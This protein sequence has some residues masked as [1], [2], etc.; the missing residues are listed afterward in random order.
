MEQQA[1][2]SAGKSIAGATRVLDVPSF[3][4]SDY[5]LMS[6]GNLKRYDRAVDWLQERSRNAD[7]RVAQSFGANELPGSSVAHGAVDGFQ[8]AFWHTYGSLLGMAYQAVDEAVLNTVENQTDRILNSRRTLPA[9]V[10]VDGEAATPPAADD[11][12]R[13]LPVGGH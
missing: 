3:S 8:S 12:P 10:I 13:I 5:S 11:A 6:Q 9:E 7:A 2:N 4:L 1:L